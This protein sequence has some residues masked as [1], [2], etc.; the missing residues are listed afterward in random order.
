MQSPPMASRRH[1]NFFAPALLCLG[2]A[3]C[4]GGSSSGGDT[5]PSVSNVS[6]GFSDAPVE[7][8]ARVVITVDYLE[9]RT[10]DGETITV[11]SFTSS[12]LGITDAETFSVD[13]LEI[14]GNDSRLVLDSVELPVGDYQDLRI[15]IVDEDINFSYVEETSSGLL[16]PIKVP[17]DELKLGSFTVA[18]TSTQT[19]V[20]EFGLRQSMT[21]NPGPQRYIL[22]PRGVRVVKLEDAATISG[23]VDLDALHMLEPCIAKVD[24]T[25]GN[26][27]Y[28]Y[29]GHGL[30]PTK[31]GDTFVRE[32]TGTEPEFDPNV[33]ADIVSP[34]VVTV[35]DATDGSYLF[36][37]L[38]PG[39]YTLAISCEAEG[40]DPVLW[41]GLNIPAPQTEVIELSLGVEQDLQC[42]L[43]L[44]GGACANP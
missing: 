38:L 39:D 1:V 2:L 29:A 27:A 9:F 15:G 4:G 14:Q 19:F 12:E 42:D 22:K 8:A 23:T 34:E 25:V 26:V 36:S 18:A 24:N 6:I 41:D 13:L 3:A 16:K 37:Y 43:P 33:P 11:D 44:L 21:Y 28:L 32:D 10:S 7:D 35:I 17:S 20:V 5:A 31:L 40:D 30:D